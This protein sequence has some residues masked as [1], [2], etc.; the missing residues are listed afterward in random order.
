MWILQGRV[1]DLPW[2]DLIRGGL[3]GIILW[4]FLAPMVLSWGRRIQVDRL[5]LGRTLAA[6]FLGVVI[7]FIPF[8]SLQRLIGLVGKVFANGWGA[9]R[10]AELVPTKQNV[11]GS[12]LDVPFVYL[13]ILSGAEAMKHARAR[14]D[15]ELQARQL[16]GQLAEARLALLQ[17][18]LHPHFFFNALQAISTF[19]YCDPKI[20]DDLIMRLTSLMR[21]ML[22]T[23]SEQTLSLRAE[24]GLINNYLY[25]EQIRFGD[26]L[27]VDWCV[28]SSVLD[29]RVPSLSI[30]PLVENAIRHGLSPKVDPGKLKISAHAQGASL[31]LSV[32]DDGVGASLPLRNSVGIGNTRE[33]LTALF[34]ESARLSI[35]T[36]PNAGFCATLWIPLQRENL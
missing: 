8:W 6:H 2:S 34:G 10:L 24:F 15:E 9:C 31:V 1:F 4:A 16:A 33:R 11:L 21:A 26:R 5:G 27:G 7:V 29:I 25:I 32:E 23:A 12:F 17:R 13:L 3:A 19:L 22:E 35:D 28:D 36:R 30:L 14:R 18:Q 20:S